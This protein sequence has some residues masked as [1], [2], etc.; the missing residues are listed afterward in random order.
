MGLLSRSPR[1]DFAYWTSAMILETVV[2]C[3]R[4]EA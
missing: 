3:W 4:V 2:V 1:K